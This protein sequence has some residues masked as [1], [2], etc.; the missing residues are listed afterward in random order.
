MDSDR[1]KCHVVIM[2]RP[3]EVLVENLLLPL[4]FRENLSATHNAR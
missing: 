3:F 4:F 2:P 1:S